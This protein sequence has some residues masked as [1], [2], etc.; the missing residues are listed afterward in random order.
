MPTPAEDLE[1]LRYHI[2]EVARSC[3]PDE[4]EYRRVRGRLLTLPVRPAFLQ[5]C[6]DYQRLRIRLIGIAKGR[7]SYA[8]RDRWVAS[9]L[10][11]LAEEAPSLSYDRAVTSV[12]AAFDDVTMKWV[13]S[14]WEE[15]VG[16]LGTHDAQAVSASRSMLE[17][18]C[19]AV[20][21]EHA[22]QWKSS[23]GMDRL[24][25]ETRQV[26]EID[27]LLGMKPLLDALDDAMRAMA[28]IR[29]AAG[30]DHGLG[31]SDERVP[32]DIAELFVNVAGAMALF[33]RRQAA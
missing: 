18:V 14:H 2:H 17:S 13:R 10:A 3:E 15:A 12:G 20:L 11:E 30:A 31:P 16:F 23:W 26:L 9:Q 6:S 33:F 21:H 1:V 28:K 24:V 4:E 32:P 25:R 22:V 27:D 29:A 7:G 19:K 5:S 8:Q